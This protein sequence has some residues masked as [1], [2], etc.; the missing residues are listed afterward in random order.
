[1]SVNYGVLQGSVLGPLLFSVYMLS[2]DI[3]IYCYADD[4]QIIYHHE[5]M[6]SLNYPS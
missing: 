4:A 1:M 5:M 2:L 6:K 3:S